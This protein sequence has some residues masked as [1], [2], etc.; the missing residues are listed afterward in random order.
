MTTYMATTNPPTQQHNATFSDA[1]DH[2]DA[3]DLLKPLTEQERSLARM[4]ALNAELQALA[5]MQRDYLDFLQKTKQ[6]SQDLA[7]G[8]QDLSDEIGKQSARKLLDS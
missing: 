1:D 4:S 6:V 7:K 2:V 8:E 5:E 3:A